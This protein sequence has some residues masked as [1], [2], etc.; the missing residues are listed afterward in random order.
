MSS[1]FNL[2]S[3]HKPNDLHPRSWI[4][5]QGNALADIV[6][7]LEREILRTHKISREHLSELLSRELHCSRGV[8][9]N[10]LRGGTSFY[11]IVVLQ[12]LLARS[13]KPQFLYRK[14]KENILTLKVNSASAKPVNAVSVLSKDLAKIVGAFAADGSLS[15]QF[16]LA[17]S[18]RQPLEKLQSDIGGII[19]STKIQ[20]SSARKQYYLAIQLNK[21]SKNVFNHLETF[22][23]RNLRTQTHYVI[24]L[25]EEYEDSV[26]AFT[27][28]IENVFEIRPSF[29]NIKR[30]KRAWRVIFSN[31]ILARYLS[32]FFGM[33]SGQKTYDVVEPERIK[34]ST[35][36]MRRSFARGVLMF[37]G[38]VTKGGKIAFSSKSKD[39]A[40]AIDEIWTKDRIAHGVLSMNKR[41][42]YTISTIIPNRTENL[43]NYFEPSTQKWKLLRWINGDKVVKPIIK[44]GGVLSAGKILLLLKEIRSCDIHFLERYFGRSYTSIRYYLNI[45]ENHGYIRISSSPHVW[46]GCISEKTTVFLD[47]HTHNMVF[48]KIKE[49]LELEK[50][51]ADVLGI[52]KATFS[53]W[54]LQRNRIPVEV[55]QRLCS[56]LGINFSDLTK[57]IIQT[58]RDI[59][60]L[61]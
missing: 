27:K 25:T 50:N 32:E 31:K 2:F 60:E 45:L 9:K 28:W 57:A 10:I 59:L 11:P 51:A 49:R 53:A 42:E 39:L 44:E 34:V 35:L 37:D 12:K 6:S 40:S 23:N 3:L 16:I 13:S 41:S 47:K 38:C 26:R 5:V 18:K 14:I 36:D 58:D 43:L 56:M 33:K 1:S 22:K 4:C 17:A 61:I 7:K 15:V 52:H 19:S 46:S 29:L 54:K 8:I 21:H 20:R 24:E 30:G 55:L 48:A